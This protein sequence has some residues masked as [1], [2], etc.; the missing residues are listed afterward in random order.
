MIVLVVLLFLAVVNQLRVIR[1]T[2]WFFFYL[3]WY[4]PSRSSTLIVLLILC[5][6]P[7]RY[8]IGGAVLGVL[9]ALPGFQFRLHHYIA[10]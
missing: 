3:K 5:L 2:G 1:K 9:A 4:V 7:R 6:S 10:S 8:A